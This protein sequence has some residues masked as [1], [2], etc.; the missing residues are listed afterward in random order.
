MVNNKSLL[1]WYMKGFSDE[2]NGTT[3]LMS[4]HKPLNTAYNVGALDA[5]YGDIDTRLDYLSDEELLVK[6]KQFIA[7]GK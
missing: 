4:K 3:S 6:I 1:E 5:E 2:L 7:N